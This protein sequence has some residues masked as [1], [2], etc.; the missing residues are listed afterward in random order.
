MRIQGM[1][2]HTNEAGGASGGAGGGGGGG[3]AEEDREDAA[4]AEAGISMVEIAAAAVAEMEAEV[5]A[6]AD[7]ERNTAKGRT[8]PDVE[9]GRRRSSNTVRVLPAPP[10]AADASPQKQRRGSRQL[11]VVP[12]DETEA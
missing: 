5:N 10:A 6:E 1:H 4:A 3:N 12:K 11:P 8:P 2:T 7:T 9:L